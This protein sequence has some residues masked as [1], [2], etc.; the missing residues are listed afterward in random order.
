MQLATMSDG[1]CGFIGGIVDEVTRGMST[2][3]LLRLRSMAARIER[4]CAFSLE[5][6]S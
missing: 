1:V 4:A 5:T 3:E 2:K 6:R